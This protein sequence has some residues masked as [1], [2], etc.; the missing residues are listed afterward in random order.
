MKLS[1]LYS[2]IAILAIVFVF[3]SCTNSAMIPE[4]E[5][6]THGIISSTPPIQTDED[7]SSKSSPTAAVSSSKYGGI[8][9][10]IFEAGPSGAIG[11]PPSM[12][13]SNA[14]SQMI[15]CIETLLYGDI[16]G[17]VHPWLAE[18]YKIADDFKSITFVLRKGVK[19]HDGSDFNA[20]VAKW[21]LDNMIKARIAQSWASVDILDDYSI[22]VNLTE[23]KNTILSTFSEGTEATPMV[24]KAAFDKNGKEWMLL[25]PV[26]TGPFKFQSFQRDVSLKFDKN[27]DYWGKDAQGN[28]LPYL[29]GIEWNFVA[30][31]MTRKMVMQTG[32]GDMVNIEAG[33]S[34]IDMQ[35]QGLAIKV[36]TADS[37]ILIPDSV[38]ADS[39][40][41]N[42]QVREAVEY[43]I[44]RESIA[45]AF[46][47][48][49]WKSPY[50]IPG[51][52]TIA[53]NPDFTLGR[54]FNPEK[55]KQLLAEAGYPNGF[56]TTLIIQPLGVNKDIPLA[57]QGDL[58]KVGIEVEL[59]YP[60]PGRYFQTLMG[61]WHN[62]AIFMHM[63]DLPN[64]NESLSDLFNMAIPSW[65]RSPDFTQAYKTSL[66]SPE[67]DAEL[68]RHCT[69]LMTQ[70][71]AIIPV[72][73]SGAGWAVQSYV[74][75]A[76]IL[77]KSRGHWWKPEQT[78]LNK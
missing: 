21:N 76:G 60:D 59:D 22:R 10:V 8:L 27:T 51:R 15:P 16:K 35:E 68:I 70:Y 37:F 11:W 40:W 67:P 33:K 18:S 63:S 72:N 69:D 6:T 32:A 24:S 48:S 9:K 7:Q 30:E 12:R 28:P 47:Y 14:Q 78:W 46:G 34:A 23:W 54:K 77:E 42:Q 36:I 5:S 2:F 41:A 71:A 29:D 26:G 50:Q 39:P 55:A 56:K 74:M 57:I 31:P 43:A 17:G 49:F 45:Q 38:N 64:F 20:E 44:D 19:F 25:N 1:I 61:T 75:D 53:Y 3:S 52:A 65:Q 58:S 4:T 62:A 13:F 66:A 73:E